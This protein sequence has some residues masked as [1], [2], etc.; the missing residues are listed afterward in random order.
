MAKAWIDEKG[1]EIPANRITRLEKLREKEAARLL[2]DAKAINDKLA[3]YKA[4]MARICDYVYTEAMDELGA[5]PG[6][7]KGNFTWYNFDRSI[8][9][10]VSISERIDFDDILIAAAKEKLD[11]FLEQHTSEDEMIRQLV[12]NAFA[13]SRG[14]LDVKRV[15][16]LVSYRQRL[17]KSKYPLF[18]EAIDLIEQSIHRPDSRRY[19]RISERMSEG[20]YKVVE[21]NFS[22]I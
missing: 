3:E 8:K 21:L 1:I 14:K 16:G 20:D 9:V 18:H 19:F 2:K 5:D 22:S 11:T 7:N 13:T 15:L 6:K 10:E 17:P 4:T 12:M